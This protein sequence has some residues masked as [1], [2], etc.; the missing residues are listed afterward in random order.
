MKYGSE[1]VRQNNTLDNIFQTLF[2]SC[3]SICIV[4]SMI[5]WLHK[6]L[7][8]VMDDLFKS[9]MHLNKWHFYS[10]MFPLVSRYDLFWCVEATLSPNLIIIID[11]KLYTFITPCRFVIKQ[12]C[13]YASVIHMHTS[14][15]LCF[16]ICTWWN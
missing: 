14:N 10:S 13:F 8:F 7:Y 2:F 11:M 16:F 6:C 3:L 1:A 15:Q 4:T 5:S 12:C 9:Y